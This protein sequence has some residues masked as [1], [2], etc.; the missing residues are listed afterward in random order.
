MLELITTIRV[1]T[2]FLLD[3]VLAAGYEEGSHLSSGRRNDRLLHIGQV[4]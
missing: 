4:T 3:S 2:L 1:F